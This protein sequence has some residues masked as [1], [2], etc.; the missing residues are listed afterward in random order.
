MAGTVVASTIN[1]D[2]GLFATNNAYLGICKAWC[3]FDGTS[4][5]IR[6]SFN[7]SSLTRVATGQYTAVFTTAMTSANYAVVFGISGQNS[8]SGNGRVIMNLNSGDNGG[9]PTTTT[10]YIQT[11]NSADSAKQDQSYTMFSVLNA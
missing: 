9:T 2:T 11:T 1:N 8:G 10:F 5:S 6:S 4:G 3:N 7:I